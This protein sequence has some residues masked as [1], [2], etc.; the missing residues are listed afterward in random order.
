MMQ[1]TVLKRGPVTVSDHL[2]SSGPGDTPFAEQHDGWRLAYVRAGGFGYRHCGRP[3][4]MAPGAVLAGYPGDDFVCSHDHVHGDRCISFLFDAELAQAAAGGS[5]AYRAGAVA[6]HPAVMVWGARAA[7]AADAG[8]PMALEEAGL[9]LAARFAQLVTGR[10]NRLS[11][12][13]ARDRRRATLAALWLDANCEEAVDLKAAADFVDLSPFHFLRIFKAT[14]G[15]TPHQYL[16]ACRL[17]RAARRLVLEDT[18]VSAIAY[19]VGFGDL[20]NFVRSF[21]RAAGVSPGR[22]RAMARSNP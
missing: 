2:C 4:E 15:V 22:W 21:R 1:T 6:P 5:D 18:A 19:E 12:I 16:V 20:S 8:E 14:L 10:D 3:F 9:A 7:A 17:R 13:A 11:I